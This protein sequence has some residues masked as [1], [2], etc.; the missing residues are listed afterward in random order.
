MED[1]MIE[2]AR[3]QQAT[4][5]EI[6]ASLLRSEG[7][8]CC[9]RNGLSSSFMFGNDTGGASVEL[10]KKDALRAAEIMKDH[11]Y[12]ISA[13]IPELLTS[14]DSKPDRGALETSRTRRSKIIII[15][16]LLIILLFSLLVLLNKY[17]NGQ[18]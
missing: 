9:V 10:L 4:D 7:V 8:E 5:A 14:A 1:K 16:T 18:S 2:I 13:E 12:E 3:F 17:F 6:L 11:G 15:I